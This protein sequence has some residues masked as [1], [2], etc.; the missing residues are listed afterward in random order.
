[1]TT[2]L[3]S[4]LF[5]IPILVLALGIASVV[6]VVAIIVRVKQLAVLSGAACV[7]VALFCLFFLRSAREEEVLFT[8]ALGVTSLIAAIALVFFERRPK[9]ESSGD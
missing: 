1:M 2:I 5:V 7:V 8:G 6:G 3:A 9:K 4:I